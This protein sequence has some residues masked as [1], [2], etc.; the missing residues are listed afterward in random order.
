MTPII[1][2]HGTLSNTVR[3]AGGV[4]RLFADPSQRQIGAVINT[5]EIAS[6]GHILLSSGIDYQ[7]YIKDNP[8]VPYSHNLDQLPVAKTIDIRQIGSELYGTIQFP[9]E[10]A[11][12]FADQVY[13]MVKFGAL[14]A[15]SLGF[16]ILQSEPLRNGTPGLRI[17]KSKLMEI[18]IVAAP[19]NESALINVR[20]L[21]AAHQKAMARRAS[22]DNRSM[23]ARRR[24]ARAARARFERDDARLIE[25]VSELRRREMAGHRQ[26][27][28]ERQGELL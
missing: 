17:T 9:P 7:N 5:E 24:A 25:T 12:P 19:A 10:G 15:T 16:R 11:N 27:E 6:D 21:T 28:F 22:V 2:R 20:S 13:A 14:N 8:F 1:Y 3:S 4:K 18:S 26:L 23:H